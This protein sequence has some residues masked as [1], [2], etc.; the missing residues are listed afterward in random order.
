MSFKRPKHCFRDSFLTE[1]RDTKGLI[2]NCGS[3]SKVNIVRKKYKHSKSRLNTTDLL[4][5]LSFYNNPFSSFSWS[6]L[7]SSNQLFWN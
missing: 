4:I 1:P 3:Y 7:E 2:V 6:I 5:F